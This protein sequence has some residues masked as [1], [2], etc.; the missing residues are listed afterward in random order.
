MKTEYI[1]RSLAVYEEWENKGIG[2]EFLKRQ[3]RFAIEE[4][5]AK[6]WS[7]ISWWYS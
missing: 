7:F 4:A 5:T 1:D 2:I 3:T 6:I